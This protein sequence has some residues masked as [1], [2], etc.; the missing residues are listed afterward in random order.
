MNFNHGWFV[1]AEA[2]PGAVLSDFKAVLMNG[3]AS[4]DV[5]FYFLH[6]FTDLAG[7]EATPL[8]GSEKFVLKFPH[9]V[10]AS[11]MWSIPFLQQLEKQTETEVVE[12]YLLARWAS[13]LPGEDVPEGPDAIARLRLA[14]MAQTEV[15]SCNQAFQELPDPVRQL[16]IDEM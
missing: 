1:Q 8:G 15:V 2:P 11:F 12:A 6:W 7:A 4:Q 10:L 14:V 5:A 16:L 9:A 3:A 13:A